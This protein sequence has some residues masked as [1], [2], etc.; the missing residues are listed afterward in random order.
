[1]LYLVLASF[2]AGRAAAVDLTSRQGVIARTPPD[3]TPPSLRITAPRY[4][5]VVGNPTPAITAE[6]SDTGSGVD[7]A[8]LEVRLDGTLLGGAACTAGPAAVTCTPPALAAGAHVIAVRLADRSG[9]LATASFSFQLLLGEGPHSLTFQAAA[10]TYMSEAA[11][12]Q[13]FGQKNFLRLQGKPR[14]RALVRFDPAELSGILGGA[15]IV[16][17][18]L[19]MTLASENGEEEGPA[20]ATIDAHR[21]TADWTETGA[22]WSC[23]T[24]AG[25]GST[26]AI[27][28]TGG[29]FA[30]PPTASV[31]QSGHPTGTV[32]FD[33]T[34]DVAALFASPSTGAVHR[35]WLLKE[36]DERPASVFSYGSREGTAA[37]AGG[38]LP[39]S[40]AAASAA[41]GHDAADAR[42]HRTSR[43]DGLPR[44]SCDHRG[45][46]RRGLGRR[47][48][49]PAGEGRWQ[50]PRRLHRRAVVRHLPAADVSRG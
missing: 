25:T 19:E 20:G 11:A 38:E 9:N 6:Y 48:R 16:S 41:D 24:P 43:L 40:R 34:P 29:T 13:N 50:R 8:T 46:L 28:W 3:K 15:T 37:A 39:H 5:A 18:G 33:V 32:R 31:A 45:V 26:C 1:V 44:F 12:K 30:V 22:T 4:F 35:G 2:V 21:L 17:A 14:N 10:D 47:S 36:A 23:A 27:P 7:L 42:D 49:D